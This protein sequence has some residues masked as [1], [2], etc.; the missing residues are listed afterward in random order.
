MVSPTAAALQGVCLLPP[1]VLTGLGPMAQLS[2]ELRVPLG[3][4][5]AAL[6][7]AQLA[8]GLSRGA[9]PTLT[10]SRWLGCYVSKG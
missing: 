1:Q 5:L 4:A 2:A 8:L 9:T 10:H 7:A 3:A 6:A